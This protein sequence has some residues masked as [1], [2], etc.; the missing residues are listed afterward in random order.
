MTEENVMFYYQRGGT[1]LITASLEVAIA[2]RDPNTVIFIDDGSGKK[3][4]NLE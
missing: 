3:P 4:I 2:R 1:E